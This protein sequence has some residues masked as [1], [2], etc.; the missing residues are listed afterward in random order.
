MGQHFLRFAAQQQPAE[1]LAPVGGHE[2]DV[3]AQFPGGM[4]DA[5]VR[6][7]GGGDVAGAWHPRQRCRGLDLGEFLARLGFHALLVHLAL[8]VRA[9][10]GQYIGIALHAH[11]RREPRRRG[12]GK[13]DGGGNGLVRKLGAVDGEQDVFEHGVLFLV[14]EAEGGKGRKGRKG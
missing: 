9:V 1:S 14:S 2:D 11:V 4:D 13:L 12:A 7:R 5:L 8:F 3:A 10:G 6:H